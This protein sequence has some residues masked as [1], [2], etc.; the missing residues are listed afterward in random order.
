MRRQ[1]F[2]LLHSRQASVHATAPPP[3]VQVRHI[4]IQRLLPRS[5]NEIQALLPHFLPYPSSSPPFLHQRRMVTSTT[6]ET[7]PL[8]PHI[9]LK[10]DNLFH[11]MDQSPSP[12][13]RE[14]ADYIKTH[15]YCPHPDHTRTRPTHISFTCPDCGTPTYCTE[16][17]WAEDYKSHLRICD[18]L[19]EINEDDHDLRSGRFFPEFDYPGVQLNEALINFTNWDTYLYTRGFEAVNEERSLRQLT[20]LLTYPTTIASVLHELSPYNLRHRMTMEG[21][22]SLAGASS[23][24]IPS[25][26][27]K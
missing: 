6:V 2:Q 8:G 9:V 25:T 11:P 24:H 5:R 15:A 7:E 12:S 21:L 19:R 26:L 13:M 10:P 1:S 17:H 14:R 4:A 16:Q 23:S 3:Q 20:R 22:K 27:N 18:T